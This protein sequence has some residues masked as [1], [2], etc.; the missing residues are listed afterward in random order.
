MIKVD[1]QWK[2]DKKK[3]NKGAGP[4]LF[5]NRTTFNR[6]KSRRDSRRIR[7]ASEYEDLPTKRELFKAT[8]NEQY[9]Q[10]YDDVNIKYIKAQQ[11]LEQY[12]E[13]KEDYNHLVVSKE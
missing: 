7:K 13:L 5:T 10:L 3:K 8:K 11:D 6:L 4:I 2:K 1:V 9:K 12:E